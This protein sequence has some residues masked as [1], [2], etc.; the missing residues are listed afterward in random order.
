MINLTQYSSVVQMLA[1]CK[2]GQ[3]SPRLFDLLIRRYLTT[4]EILLAER[5]SLQEIEG[6]SSVTVSKIVEA[7]DHLQEAQEFI[8][9]LKAREITITSRFEEP[10]PAL[11]LELNDPPTLLYVRGQLSDPDKKTIGLLGAENASAEGIE[12]TSALAKRFSE[13]GIQIIS[14]LTLGTDA[15]VHLGSKVSKGS[16]FAVID[17]GFEN[18]TD[19][20]TMPLAIDIALTGGVISEYSPERQVSEETIFDSNRLLVG[21]S[22]AVVITEVYSDS[23]RVHDIIEFCNDIGKLA[24]IFIDPRYGALADETSL[25]KALSN[26]L[27][28]IEGYDKVDNIIKVLV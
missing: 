2:Y 21:L 4:E 24:F 7:S 13:A 26:G 1:I 23:K 3:I 8:S 17:R 19:P 5:E 9:S 27:I 12:I 20:A 25:A 11:L 28:P 18:L 6:L 14:S 16:S 15:A 10:Y 22:Q